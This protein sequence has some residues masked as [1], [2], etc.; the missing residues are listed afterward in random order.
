M[1]SCVLV[2][3]LVS[4][5]TRIECDESGDGNTVAEPSDVDPIILYAPSK[6]EQPPPVGPV[7]CTCGVF[8]SGQ[9]TKNSQEPPKGHPALLHEHPDPFPCNIWG[10]K[11]CTNRCLDIIVK[12]LPNS[13]TILCG[14]IDRDCH[15]ERVSTEKIH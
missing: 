13:P 6:T 3:F 14:S 11:Q 9:F 2:V 15:R 8:L 10:N 7:P 1:K 4:C 12:H 5:Y